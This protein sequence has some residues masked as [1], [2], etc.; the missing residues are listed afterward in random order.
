MLKSLEKLDIL[1]KNRIQTQ[2]KFLNPRELV[3]ENNIQATI[4]LRQITDYEHI[5]IHM[6]G[7]DKT[8]KN[9]GKKYP[10]KPIFC[11]IVDEDETNDNC[12]YCKKA[13]DNRRFKR[14]HTGYAIVIHLNAENQAVKI[15]QADK[16][17]LDIILTK[18]SYMEEIQDE[19]DLTKYLIEITINFNKDSKNYNDL[20][21]YQVNIF[22]NSNKIKM[23]MWK[24]VINSSNN[25][26]I[27]QAT[28][29][30]LLKE[31]GKVIRGKEIVKNAFGEFADTF[32]DTNNGE[33]TDE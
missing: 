17:L 14:M 12:E 11:Q 33:N 13:K 25:E 22:N 30:S 4:L 5:Y 27:R 2:S 1:R 23:S 20:Y 29:P 32:A 15:L 24:E 8:D 26:K 9:T 16:K 6:T 18:L 31:D 3:N 7:G 21:E 19:K 10:R 28:N